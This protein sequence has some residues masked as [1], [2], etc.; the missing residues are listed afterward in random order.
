MSNKQLIFWMVVAMIAPTIWGSTYIVTTELLPADKPLIASV[1]RALPAG[2][3]L[4][5]LGRKLPQGVWWMR[6]IILGLLNIGGFFYCLFVAAYLLPGGVAALVMSCQPIIVMLLGAL[7]LKNKL[8]A[9]QFVACL[10]GALGVSL[11]VLEPNMELP[12]AGV[13]AGLAGAM[14][15]ATGIVLTKRWGKPEGVS[16][17]TFTGWQLVVG[18]L[19][20][21]P[22]G[23]VQEGFPTELTLNNVI[24]YTY[25]SLIGALVAYVLWFKAIEKLP[26]VTVSFISF[27]SPLSAT[28]LGYFILGEVLTFSQ[29]LGAGVIVVAIAVS[30]QQLFNRTLASPSTDKSLSKA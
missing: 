22:I 27:A 2:I 10:I 1:L 28:L 26:V 3:L 16:L 15:M 23:L 30:Q 29:I 13:L 11:L 20:L 4:V 24:G 18:G 9:R 25:L 17:Y 5:L 14:S 12:T 21:L 6:S 7:L 19:F 8:K